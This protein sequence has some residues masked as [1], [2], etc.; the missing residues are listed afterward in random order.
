[1]IKIY[2]FVFW[3]DCFSYIGWDLFFKR[4]VFYYFGCF[5]FSRKFSVLRILVAFSIL[6]FKVF[7]LYRFIF[8][9]RMTVFTMVEFFFVVVKNCS[10]FLILLRFHF[11]EELGCWCLNIFFFNWKQWMKSIEDCPFDCYCFSGLQCVNGG[12]HW[13]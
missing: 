1:M 7:F 2:L 4:G 5:V 12:L 9:L 6:V 3:S 8:Y 13:R 10:V 11:L